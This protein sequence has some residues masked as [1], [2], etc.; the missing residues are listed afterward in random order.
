[1]KNCK[2]LYP[3]RQVKS[4]VGYRQYLQEAFNFA[5]NNP[6]IKDV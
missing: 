2:V 3:K 6:A 1:M 4:H 5:E